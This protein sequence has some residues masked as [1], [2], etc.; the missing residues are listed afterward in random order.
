MRSCVALGID[1]AAG[2]PLSTRE[3]AATESPRCSAMI[4]R[5]AGRFASLPLPGRVTFEVCHKGDA[6]LT[7]LRQR[8]DI[9]ARQRVEH[10]PFRQRFAYTTNDPAQS[11][12]DAVSLWRRYANA[13]AYGLRSAARCNG[14]SCQCRSPRPVPGSI[15][16]TVTDPT[17]AAIPNA[18]ITLKDNGTNAT[19]T[20]TS[21][22]DGVYNFGQL[23]PDKFTLTATRAGI[24]ARR[25]LQNRHD[26]PGAGELDQHSACA[27]RY[28]DTV[29]CLGGHGL[30]PRYGDLEHWWD[31]QLKRHSAPAVVQP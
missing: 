17:G 3:M 27:G 14:F 20:A 21:N 23:P 8:L 4:L 18:T 28:V 1:F 19:Q 13:T 30:R 31:H 12:D 11:P 29:N 15:Q 26:H 6:T 7:S 10:Y 22:G 24:P 2:A 5:L 25:C 16:G 9:Q